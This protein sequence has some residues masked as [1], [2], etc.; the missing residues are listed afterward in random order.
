MAARQASKACE[1]EAEPAAKRLHTKAKASRITSEFLGQ[2]CRAE[3]PSDSDHSAILFKFKLDEKPTEISMI[4]W[5]ILCQYGYNEQWGFP[6]D[7]YCRRGESNACYVA[8]LKRTAEELGQHA[9]AHEPQ[10]ILL[11]E[12]AEPHEY[13]TGVIAEEV[14]SQLDGLGY[15]VLSEGEFVTAVKAPGAVAVDLQALSLER[16]QGKM[17]VV[18]SGDLNAV[19]VNVHLQWEKEGSENEKK[20]RAALESVLSHLKMRYPGVFIMLAGDTNRVPFTLRRVDKEAATIEQLV[21]GLGELGYPPGPT[22]VRWNGDEK[23]SEMTYADFALLAS[24]SR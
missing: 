6:Y 19:F 23:K 11:Q 13:G 21:D 1:A 22:N 15:H 8:R 16:Q 2:V 4:S 5:N 18:Y 7:G 10:A 17:H 24:S 9:K 3:V 14:R 20:S 12:C